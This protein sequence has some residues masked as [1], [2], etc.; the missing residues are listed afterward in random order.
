MIMNKIGQWV[1]KRCVSR[2]IRDAV[3][4]DIV[5]MTVAATRKTDSHRAQV[6]FWRHLLR[7]LPFLLAEK[8]R[9][10]WSRAQSG[11]TCT[12]MR[13]AREPRSS[14]LPMTGLSIG[15]ACCLTILA[16]TRDLRIAAPAADQRENN[17]AA[18]VSAPGRFV[19]LIPARLNLSIKGTGDSPADLEHLRILR[20]RN[21]LAIEFIVMLA[22]GLVFMNSWKDN[23]RGR[24]DRSGLRRLIVRSTGLVVTIVLLTRLLAYLLWPYF[25]FL[26]EKQMLLYWLIVLWL[27]VGGISNIVPAIV[28]SLPTAA[29][30]HP[31]KFAAV[32]LAFIA[33]FLFG[34]L[35]IFQQLVQL[36][37]AQAGRNE[38]RTTLVHLDIAGD[39]P[40]S[41]LLRLV[42]F[43]RQ[44]AT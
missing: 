17:T 34:T 28:L 29:T 18:A 31:R 16:I 24:M 42:G 14:I 33:A 35:L 44:A 23:S 13:A 12:G 7:S 10:K 26:F 9:R 21:L 20:A 40:E 3:L 2:E 43:D 19:S 5:E 4:G 1:L 36:K 41:R 30:R 11:V 38:L 37:D 6:W 32:Y 8:L 22:A 39:G 25:Q 15:L 27:I